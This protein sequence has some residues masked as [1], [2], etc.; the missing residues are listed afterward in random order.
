MASTYPHISREKAAEKLNVSVRTIDRYIRRGFLE[1]KRFDR[2]V[3][4]STPSFENYYQEQ[5]EKGTIVATPPAERSVGESAPTIEISE[6]DATEIGA[7]FRAAPRV[8]E[9]LGGRHAHTYDLQPVAIYKNLYEELKGQYDEQIKRLEG[10]HYRVGQLEAQVKNMVPMLEYKKEHRRLE[11]MDR[12]YKDDIRQAKVRVIET[13][14]LVE[15][16]RFNKNVY[17][18]LVYGMLALQPIFW[19]LLQG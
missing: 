3:F 2:N 19:V 5:I 4:I 16:E 6:E 18:A 9:A 17:I 10:A 14:R 8:A 1:V 7:S 11:L 15:G 12:Q 13:K